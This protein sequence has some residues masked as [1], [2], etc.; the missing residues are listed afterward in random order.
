MYYVLNK[1]N[2][3]QTFQKLVHFLDISIPKVPDDITLP[4]EI[5]SITEQFE[6]IEIF[7]TW[8]PALVMVVF[9]SRAVII[10]FVNLFL[11]FFVPIEAKKRNN[12]VQP[13]PPNVPPHQPQPLQQPQQYPQ[14]YPQQHQ[15]H[16][17]QAQ[18]PPVSVQ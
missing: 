15:Q 10:F 14:Q 18:Q 16:S 7:G 12:R 13:K 6:K 5:P 2:I 4:P 9:F 17:Q 8:F 3:F 1:N 11:L